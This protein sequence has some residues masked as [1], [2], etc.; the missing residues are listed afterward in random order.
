MGSVTSW[1]LRVTRSSLMLRCINQVKDLRSCEAFTTTR[2]NLGEG[3]LQ[4]WPN[5][6]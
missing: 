3:A 1:T 5:I 6:S 2:E 4:G